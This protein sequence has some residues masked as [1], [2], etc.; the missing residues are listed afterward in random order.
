VSVFDTVEFRIYA[1]VC[2][3]LGLK[4]I[5]QAF[6]VAAARLAKGSWRNPEDTRLLG[7]STQPD[8]LVERL[9]AGHLNALEN[10]PLFMVTGLLFVLL[11][12]TSESTLQAYAYTFFAARVVHSLSYGIAVQPFRTVG[13]LVGALCQVGMCTQIL[14]SAFR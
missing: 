3:A 14:Q 5:L 12:R 1:A 8:P 13:F 11:V 2:A 6:A 4:M 7:G 10:E 9:R